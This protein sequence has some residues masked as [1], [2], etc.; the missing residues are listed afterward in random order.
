MRTFK[1]GPPQNTL[2]PRFRLFCLGHRNM[3]GGILVPSGVVIEKW[4][5]SEGFWVYYDTSPD[6][7]TAMQGIRSIDG[8]IEDVFPPLPARHCTRRTMDE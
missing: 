2:F 4:N 8:E 6:I 3:A 5:S 7:D 1:L